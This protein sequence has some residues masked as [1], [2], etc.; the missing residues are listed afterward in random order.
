MEALGLIVSHVTVLHWDLE[1]SWQAGAG[2]RAG[3][4]VR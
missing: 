3:T 4:R 1:H 2:S